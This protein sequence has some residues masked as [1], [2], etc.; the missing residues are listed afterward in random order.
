MGFCIEWLMIQANTKVRFAILAMTLRR[1]WFGSYM[2]GK[3]VGGVAF[4]VTMNM[5]RSDPRK[6]RE[7]I[8]ISVY[9]VAPESI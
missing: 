4:D 9:T 8:L 1:G 7:G 6:S 5:A 2:S 3:T